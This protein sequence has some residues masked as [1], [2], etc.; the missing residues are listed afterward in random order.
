MQMTATGGD[1]N[2]VMVKNKVRVGVRVTHTFGLGTRIKLASGL[3]S[4]SASG[5]PS[6]PHTPNQPASGLRGSVVAPLVPPA[7]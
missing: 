5:G 2:R 3:E 7:E 1:R 4:V 6:C